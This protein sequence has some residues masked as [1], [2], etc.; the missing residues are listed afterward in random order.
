M[1]IK[2][3]RQKLGDAGALIETVIGVG[4]KMEGKR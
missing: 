4:Y 3:L 2:T 1:H